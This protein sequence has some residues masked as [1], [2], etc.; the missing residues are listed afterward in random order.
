MDISNWLINLGSLVPG[1]V[2]T[3]CSILSMMKDYY[4]EKAKENLE[5]FLKYLYS[6]KEIFKEQFEDKEYDERKNNYINMVVDFVIKEKQKEKIEYLA[7]V[8]EYIVSIDN[9]QE[10]ILLSYLDLLG[11][12]RC[13]DISTLILFYDIERELNKYTEDERD[14]KLEYQEEK[15]NEYI[16]ETNLSEESF[17]YVEQKL[18]GKGLVVAYNGIIDCNMGIFKE[19]SD[20][21]RNF[22]NILKE[23]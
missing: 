9:I 5:E 20:Y 3:A 6:N 17:Q 12:L 10:D 15:I 7:K 11:E 19:L 23:R 18:K 1:F 14:K 16:K 2:G 8:T 13:I 4:E 22:I 21:G